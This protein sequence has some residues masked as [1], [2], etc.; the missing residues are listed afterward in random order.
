MTKKVTLLTTT[1]FIFIFVSLSTVLY[2][3]L[4][5]EDQNN[6]EISFVTNDP[7][8]CLTLINEDFLVG[9]WSI[10]GGTDFQEYYVLSLDKNNQ[11][12]L[13]TYLQDN[14]IDNKGEWM[15]F[16]DQKSIRL[17]FADPSPHWKEYLSTDN[18]V[19]KPPFGKE[20]VSYS[21][22]DQFIEFQF[23]Y[24]LWNY[25]NQTDHECTQDRIYLDI[26]QSYLRKEMKTESKN[27]C[28]PIQTLLQSNQWK[29]EEYS[30]SFFPSGEFILTTFGDAINGEG[31][32]T[33]V[34]GEGYWTLDDYLK[35]QF[36]EVNNIPNTKNVFMEQNVHAGD[37][38]QLDFKITENN[39]CKEISVFALFDLIFLKR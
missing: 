16:N 10:S 26:F 12:I 28:D 25:K 5:T 3:Y 37:V 34:I 35:L 13:K 21:F 30:I 24:E 20:V 33:P 11:F 2:Q 38:L 14:V 18:L 15:F 29:S 4:S 32:Y 19:E 8:E 36:N 22:K 7:K 39:G 1:S 9:T 6:E 27:A 23:F 17:F 31:I